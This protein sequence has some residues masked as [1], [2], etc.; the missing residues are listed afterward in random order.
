MKPQGLSLMIPYYL[1]IFDGSL[2]HWRSRKGCGKWGKVVS[3]RNLIFFG[4]WPESP[5]GETT[6]LSNPGNMVY[7]YWMILLLVVVFR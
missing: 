6:C 1:M 4:L 2:I 5:G 7:I 3:G